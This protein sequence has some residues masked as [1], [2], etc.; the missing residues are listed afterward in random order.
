VTMTAALFPELQTERDF[1]TTV[2]DTAHW[3]GWLICHFRPAMKADGTWM[4]PLMA[5]GAGYPDLTLV[6][7][8]RLVFAELKSEHGRLAPRQKRWLDAL[9]AV[10]GCE[11]YVF[12]PSDWDEIQAVLA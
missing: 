8:E 1:T 10:K 5:D 12:R 11:V 7:G 2:I 6:R 9:R 4:T 3:R